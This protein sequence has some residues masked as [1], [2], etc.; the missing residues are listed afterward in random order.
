M[1]VA[2][3]AELAGVSVRTIRHYHAIGLLAVP[4]RVGAWRDYG[5]DDAERLLRIRALAE[6][7]VPLAEI[8][9]LLAAADAG[10]GLPR[11]RIDAALAAVSERIADL[12]HHRDRLLALR[13]AAE[14]GA[15]GPEPLRA[16]YDRLF[17][18][19][20]DDPRITAALARER[21][22]SLLLLQLG[23]VDPG[24]VADL[25]AGMDEAAT[26][27]TIRIYRRLTDLAE[28]GWTDDQITAFVADSR[29]V[30][31]RFGPDAA[32]AAVRWWADT[33]LA[34]ALAFAAFPHPGQRLAIRR[35]LDGIAAD[36]ARAEP[37]PKEPAQP[38]DD[39]EGTP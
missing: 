24:W 1:R 5:L 33:R 29:A 9:E 19:A 27:A 28:P 17:A 25:A 4:G 26:D 32:A 20:A 16:A 3:L 13:A 37:G 21:R 11:H 10:G 12:E 30:L 31:T 2:E 36:A 8:G 35:L 38:P 18:A 14:A 7:G 23:L 6:A 22:L 34:R 39:R 15:E